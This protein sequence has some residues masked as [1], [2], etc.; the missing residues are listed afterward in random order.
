MVELRRNNNVLSGTVTC[1]CCNSSNEFV[2]GL[3]GAVAVFARKGSRQNTRTS[4]IKFAERIYTFDLTY[5]C[6]N[7]NYVVTGQGEFIEEI[8]EHDL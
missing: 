2:E 1:P 7:C 5:K 4:G 8:D 6:S 3:N